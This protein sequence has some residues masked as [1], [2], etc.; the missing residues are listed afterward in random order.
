MECGSFHSVSAG[1]RT[2]RKM[3]ATHIDKQTGKISHLHT[4]SAYF[5]PPVSLPP[6]LSL[7]C[8]FCLSLSLHLSFPG[9][10]HASSPSFRLIFLPLLNSSCFFSYVHFFLHHF[11][12]NMSSVYPPSVSPLSLCSLYR[13]F[14][15]EGK[16]M[17]LF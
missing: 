10:L 9:S 12:D 5:P 16:S 4:Y 3:S 11:R 17:S 2:L 14:L 15:L 13:F 8:S 1:A 6:P 7:P